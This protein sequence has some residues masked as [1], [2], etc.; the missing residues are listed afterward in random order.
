MSTKKTVALILSVLLALGLS[1]CSP[2]EALQ[3]VKN[4][5]NPLPMLQAQAEKAIAFIKEKMDDTMLFKGDNQ[6]VVTATDKWLQHEDLL[7]VSTVYE[8]KL[9]KENLQRLPLVLSKE[10]VY[11]T[12]EQYS[13]QNELEQLE[14]VLDWLYYRYG[15]GK[16]TEN[17]VKAL[18]DYG[19]DRT[20]AALL[21]EY[22]RKDA[23]VE[24]LPR[25]YAQLVD[26]TWLQTVQSIALD[27]AI[28]EQEAP[29]EEE[30]ETDAESE[31]ELNSVEK[32][33]L[34][35][36][37]KAAHEMLQEIVLLGKTAH[38]YEYQ[39]TDPTEEQWHCLRSSVYLDGELYTVYCWTKEKVFAKNR[40]EL[41]LM[42]Q[43]LRFATAEDNAVLT[44]QQQKDAAEE[45]SE[46]A[47]EDEGQPAE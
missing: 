30:E 34:E 36:E 25:L 20:E 26:H 28:I 18:M 31:A 33:Q 6:L 41:L 12:V 5:E 13:C 24:E 46:P 37:Q 22:W 8:M 14:Q 42:M 21:E 23:T 9:T 40:A 47:T 44:A 27:F 16:K 10:D 1:G 7:E 38:L 29:E 3:M 35:R 39:Y 45:D 4:R 17:V 43:S 19:F 2:Q 11:F 32:T 15:K